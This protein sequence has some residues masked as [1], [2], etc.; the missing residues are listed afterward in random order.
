MREA[1]VQF[2]QLDVHL[3]EQD[4]EQLQRFYVYASSPKLP[5]DP[6]PFLLDFGIYSISLLGCRNVPISAQL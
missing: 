6:H 2:L 3:K 1:A 5:P 4:P